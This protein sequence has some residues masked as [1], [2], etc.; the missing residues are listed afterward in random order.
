MAG[1]V[2]PAHLLLPRGRLGWQGPCCWPAAAPQ[3]WD[4]CCPHVV[5]LGYNCPHYHT[6]PFLFDEKQ[7]RSKQDPLSWH[8]QVLTLL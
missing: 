4:T 3:G 2:Q 8:N 5:I 1:A 6:P 7:S